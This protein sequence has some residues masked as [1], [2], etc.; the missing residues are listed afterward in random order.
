MLNQEVSY[1]ILVS[2][3]CLNVHNFLC[4]F[5]WI[6]HHGSGGK[7]FEPGQTQGTQAASATCRFCSGCQGRTCSWYYRWGDVCHHRSCT[8]QSEGTDGIDVAVTLISKNVG[9]S[10]MVLFLEMGRWDFAFQPVN[11]WN[12][13]HFWSDFHNWW[14]RVATGN[15]KHGGNSRRFR[16]HNCSCVF[17]CWYTI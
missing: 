5:E 10:K 6:I 11:P 14:D 3:S 15:R 4:I 2:L 17:A 1:Q 7:G 12:G 9:T 13:H 8:I 16:T